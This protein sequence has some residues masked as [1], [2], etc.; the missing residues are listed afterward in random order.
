MHYYD[1]RGVF[2][3]YRVGADDRTWRLWRD[4]PGFSQRFTGDVLDGGST[5]AGRWQ[6]S[7]DGD[8]WDDDLAITSTRVVGAPPLPGESRG[9]T[10]VRD[11]RRSS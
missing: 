6:L 5:I 7:R 3:V 4:E 11:R 10:L 1:S 8:R 9:D 2:R